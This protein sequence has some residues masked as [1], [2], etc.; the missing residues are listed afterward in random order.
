MPKIYSKRSGRVPGGAVLVDRSTDYGNPFEIGRDGTREQ[1]CDKYDKWICE[2]EQ[3]WLRLQMRLALRGKDLVC[4][5]E[6]DRCHA[7]TVM[8]IAN[9]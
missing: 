3:R 2:P 4:W 6:P 8:K 5:C 7:R 1:V 9:S